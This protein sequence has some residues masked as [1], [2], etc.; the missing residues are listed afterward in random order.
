MK[1]N[2]LIIDVRHQLPWHRRYVSNTSTMM[3]WGAWLLLW[4]PFLLVWAL[5]ELEKSHLI[6]QIFHALS[7]GLE[8]GITSL[9]ACAVALLLWSNYVPAKSV[10]RTHEKDVTDYAR[11]FELDETQIHQGRAQKISVVHHDE[12]GRI[13]HID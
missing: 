11:Y 2:N 9:I 8:H 4:R 6:H 5:V 10:K 12:M 1:S 3:M 7:L 13:T